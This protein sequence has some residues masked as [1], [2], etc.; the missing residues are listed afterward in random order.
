MPSIK[1][2]RDGLCFSHMRVVPPVTL[3]SGRFPFS[4]R[5]A[6]HPS[7]PG[8]TGAAKAPPGLTDLKINAGDPV[9]LSTEDG[10]FIAFAIG[11]VTDISADRVTAAM[12]APLSL[13]SRQKKGS[14]S[15]KFKTEIRRAGAGG[16]VGSNAAAASGGGSG[17][18]AG[19]EHEIAEQLLNA[20]LRIDRDALAFSAK[21]V[22]SNIAEMFVAPAQPADDMANW[23]RKRQLVVD[24]IPP[25]FETLSADLER[26]LCG[27]MF[28]CLCV[29]LCVH[30]C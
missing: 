27:C 29:C 21:Q 7:H 28:M 16:G 1:R 5:F 18:G 14:K 22:R 8:L 23:E 26:E 6:R 24:L 13:S 20:V 4:Y 25:V 10:K 19:D 2:E 30:A 15:S 3:G 17:G 9:I 12:E 11:V